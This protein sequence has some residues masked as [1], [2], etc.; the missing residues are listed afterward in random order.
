MSRRRRLRI[1]PAEVK[2]GAWLA[3][4]PE[5][6]PGSEPHTIAVGQVEQRAGIDG[7]RIMCR[8][9]QLPPGRHQVALDGVPVGTVTVTR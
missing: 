5:Q 4:T 2:A 9:P 6:D 1:E 8:C 3:I 7:G